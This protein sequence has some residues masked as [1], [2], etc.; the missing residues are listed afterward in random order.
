MQ[1]PQ[2][3]YLSNYEFSQAIT[4]CNTRL[5][6]LKQE[7]SYLLNQ[8]NNSND[9]NPSY[10]FY[11]PQRRPVFPNPILY[12][13]QFIPPVKK[14]PIK[15]PIKTTPVMTPHIV[16]GQAM[17]QERPDKNGFTGDEFRMLIAGGNYLKNESFLNG[18]FF[19]PAITPAIDND[20]AD[21]PRVI[22][23]TKH[24]HSLFNIALSTSSGILFSFM[25]SFCL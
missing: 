18:I 16:Y 13:Y 7:Q 5:N 10:N 22:A 3:A 15:Q 14:D 2:K 23:T 11:F 8:R 6:R 17:H 4:R 12:S 20:P 1:T 24:G 21:L 9:F 25:G 19:P